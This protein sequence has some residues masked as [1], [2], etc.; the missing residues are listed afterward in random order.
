MNIVNIMNKSYTVSLG[1]L[2][3]IIFL[4]VMYSYTTKGSIYDFF[5][6]SSL[7]KFL[8]N[9]VQ[10]D[11]SKLLTEYILSYSDKLSNKI[12]PLHE[13]LGLWTNDNTTVYVRGNIPGEL[14]TYIKDIIGGVLNDFN[15]KQQCFKLK[16]VDLETIITKRMVKNMGD[17][18]TRRI[19]VQFFVL[20]VPNTSTRKFNIQWEEYLLG[21]VP[22][23]QFLHPEGASDEIYNELN[24]VFVHGVDTPFV[25]QQAN[26]LSA[27]IDGKYFNKNNSLDGVPTLD[28][29]YQK[30]SPC[31]TNDTRVEASLCANAL[32]NKDWNSVTNVLGYA[33]EPCK[34]E[35]LY[36][37][38]WDRYG[39]YQQT[40]DS[41]MCLV[42]HNGYSKAN[43]DL[44]DNPTVYTLPFPGE[45]L[46]QSS[47]L[48]YAPD[49]YSYVKQ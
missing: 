6:N 44:Y 27:D 12:N 46:K 33:Q 18:P 15:T 40:K 25:E 5:S 41:P 11:K 26:T 30:I 10:T 24:R 23:I 28:Q 47:V 7:C 14:E 13:P 36:G 1:L 16:L 32:T 45:N 37:Q 21:G 49:I 34:Q 38:K 2:G 31:E 20:D 17:K 4:S 42:S 3:T 29:R 19:F 35:A 9:S 48:P 8:K 39:V 22:K 43:P